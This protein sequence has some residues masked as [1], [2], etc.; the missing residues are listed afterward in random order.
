MSTFL[1]SFNATTSFSGGNAPTLEVLI[2]GAVVSSIDMVLGASSY[3]LLIDY[4]GAAPSSVSIR[5]AGSSGDPGDA[6]TV[7]A[8]SINNNALNVSTDLTATMLAQSQSS[9]INAA[10]SFYGHTTPT[11]GAPDITGTAGD[12][13]QVSGTNNADS[14]DALGGNDYV[15]GRGGD[16]QI[17]GGAGSDYIF[18]EDGNDTILGGSGFDV[19]FG[20]AGDDIIFGEGDADYLIGGAGS[21]L[22]NGGAGDDN[23][24]G[25]AGDDV[26]F[27]ED[28]N[29]LL[30]GDSGNDLL[31][32]D[33]GND[34]IVGGAGDDSMAGGLGDDQLIGGTGNDLMSGGDGDDEIIGEAG[35]DTISGGAGDDNIY[36]GDGNDIING[37]DDDDNIHGDDGDDTIGGDAGNDTIIGGAG[38]DTIDG[39]DGND[40]IHGHG[41]DAVTISN[42]LFNNPNIVYSEET[43]SFYQFIATTTDWNSA[44]TLA[45]SAQLSGVSGHLANVTSQAELDFVAN[46]A[47]GS[48]AWL[49]GSDDASEGDWYWVDGPENAVQFWE[50]TGG[51]VAENNFFNIWSPGD[52]NNAGGTQNSTM[53]TVAG[54]VYDRADTESHG[55]VIEWEGGLFSDDNAIDILSGGAGN[56]WLYGW[57]GND[58]LNGGADNDNLFG[59]AGNDTLNGDAGTDTIVGDAGDDIIDGGDNDD[60]LVGGDGSDTISGGAGSDTLYAGEIASA[61]LQN[62]IDAILAA[63]PG[64]QYYDPDTSDGQ[65]GSFYLYTT[66]NYTWNDALTNAQATL[67]NGVGGHLAVIT[68]ADENSFVASLIS[69]DTWIGGSDAVVEGEWRWVGGAE[70]GQQFW[71]GTASGTSV[72]GFYENWNGGEPNNSG[73]EDAVEMNNG[74]GWNDQGAGSAQDSVIEWDGADLLVFTTDDSGTVNTLDGGDGDDFLYSASGDDI[75]RGGNGNDTIE[76]NNGTDTIY[77]DAGNDTIT[78]GAGADT[79]YGGDGDDVIDADFDESLVTTEQGW[80][81]DYYDLSTSP[82]SLAA[83]GFTLNGGQ[84]NT[85]ASTTSGVTQDLTAGNFD[86]GNNFALRFETTLTIT[87]GGT[88]TFTTRSD[89]GSKL[90]LDGVEI[91]DNDGLHGARTETSAGQSL[92]AGTY[93]LVATFFERGGG[94]I[95]EVEMSGPDTGGTFTDLGPYVGANVQSV[96]GFNDTLYGGDGM[97]TLFGG[98]G[99]DTFVFEAATAFNDVDTIVSFDQSQNDVIDISDILSGLGVNA[100]NISDYV[101]V[102]AGGVFVDI[103]GSG[104]FNAGNQIISFGGT[105]NV[106]DELTMLNNSNLIV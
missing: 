15:R 85:N 5:F 76:G 9:T 55:Y 54:D 69:G 49:G 89:D 23:L 35:T 30:I 87:T 17:N 50:G 53:L 95:M 65:V 61:A 18:G 42:I 3:D 52:P 94:Q 58:I 68:S 59:G 43:G 1:L 104:T 91:V 82:N 37:G 64:V 56:D 22:L 39:D 60:F 62:Q 32:G 90:F 4:T 20:N 21:D 8:M 100:G 36:G 45:T 27:G 106:S 51:T 13:G 29:D 28:G 84:D 86:S 97:D 48:E 25:D 33:D 101:D 44:R 77:G 105:S 88:Y 66:T 12:D 73:D 14:I 103:L 74:G 26:L 40:V 6:I 19:I 102:T 10:S 38:A 41:L 70:D 34:T 75:L 83:A 46:L 93:T 11:L 71:Q 24:I 47:G 31:F 72:G 98:F 67:I 2:G 79:I 81:Y 78:G 92:A 57:G 63:N 99:A 7:N 96:S 16:D 80:E